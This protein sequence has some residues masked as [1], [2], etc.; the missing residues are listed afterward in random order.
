MRPGDAVHHARLDPEQA[1]D[2]I[3]AG[4]GRI[5][6]DARPHTQ[7]R[8]GAGVADD[9]V[10][11]VEPGDFGIV[12]RGRP[13]AGR[14]AVLD[15]FDRHPFRRGDEP[16]ELV[17]RRPVS[18]RDSRVAS[19]QLPPEHRSSARQDPGLAAEPLIERHSQPEHRG[20]RKR[21]ATVAPE[22]ACRRGRRAAEHGLG[23][24]DDADRPDLVGRRRDEQ[25]ALR[26]RPRHQP[27]LALFQVAETALR[28]PRE[29]AARAAGE[30]V[31]LDQQT[32]KTLER[33]VPERRRAGDPAADDQDVELRIGVDFRD[34]ASP[35][36]NAIEAALCTRGRAWRFPSFAASRHGRTDAILACEL[37]EGDGG[38]GG[39]GANWA[40]WK[41]M[42]CYRSRGAEA[43]RQHKKDQHPAADLLPVERPAD[44][45]QAI[46]DDAEEGTPSSVPG[47]L[48]RPR[49]LIV[50]PRNVAPIASIRN[51]LPDSGA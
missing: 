38:G 36:E 33:Q 9:D 42:V 3:C 14:D 47:T 48:A 25:V 41:R 40:A 10:V 27:E 43:D 12:Q 31:A 49:A 22:R 19:L 6:D 50:V 39:D 35:I 15:E 23:R 2:A 11:G 37:W 34:K 16:L 32:P 17:S 26:D 24:Q 46:L 45:Q 18:R 4:P 13:A 7:A 8:A 28:N 44:Q 30:I 51:A 29:R 1:G 20:A 5:D 21:M